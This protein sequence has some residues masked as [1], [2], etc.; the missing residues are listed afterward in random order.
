MD[1]QV[2]YFAITRKQIDKLLGK[3]KAKDY[4]SK[5]SIFSVTVGANDFLNNYLLPVLSVGARISQ[6]PDAFIDDMINHL[7][8]QLTVRKIRTFFDLVTWVFVIVLKKGNLIGLIIGD[9]RDFTVWM[10]GNL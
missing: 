3:S 7:R 6:S 9:C 8:D 10:L 1:I 5:K 4:I 2:D